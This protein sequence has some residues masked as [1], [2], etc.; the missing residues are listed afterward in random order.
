MFLLF[1]FILHVSQLTLLFGIIV[2][3]GRCGTNNNIIYFLCPWC[4]HLHVWALITGSYVNLVL[5]LPL[6]SHAVGHV[7]LH[8]HSDPG[9]S[10][11]SGQFP[12]YLSVF[13]QN[14]I[15][16]FCSFKSVTIW[17]MFKVFSGLSGVILWCTHAVH[18]SKSVDLVFMH[19]KQNNFW[20]PFKKTRL[21]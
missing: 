7:L 15:L 12:I 9:L 11:F 3:Y 2:I 13:I 6:Q 20:K 1:A 21:I 4:D 18:L 17:Y 14:S 19:Q 16:T 5:E 10:F 8:S